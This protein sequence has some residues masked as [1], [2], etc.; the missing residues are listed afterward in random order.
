MYPD[1]LETRSRIH[2]TACD[3]K[4]LD[5]VLEMERGSV[6]DETSVFPSS[7]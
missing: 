5:D 4:G 2:S 1:K 3:N 6:A 7:K